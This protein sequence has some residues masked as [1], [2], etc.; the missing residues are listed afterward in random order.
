MIA[1][2][3]NGIFQSYS[4]YIKEAN[5]FFSHNLVLGNIAVQLKMQLLSFG[6][7]YSEHENLR[8]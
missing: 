6:N 8:T 5:Y 7:N 3:K 4:D 1:E 2:G